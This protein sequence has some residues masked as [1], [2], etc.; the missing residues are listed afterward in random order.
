MSSADTLEQ[1]MVDRAEELKVAREVRES[2][3]TPNTYPEA[4]ES[5]YGTDV[6]ETVTGRKYNFIE[7]DLT[8]FTLE[9]IAYPLSTTN[10]FG[11]HAKPFWSVAQHSVFVVEILEAQ[12]VYQNH[13]LR[14]GLMHD[15]AEAM[16]NDVPRPLKPRIGEAYVELTEIADDA[17]GRRF[18]I[19]EYMM[20]G[21]TV[22]MADRIALVHE[23]HRVMRNGPPP[24][25]LA[26]YPLP[27]GLK[28]P[29]PMNMEEAQGAYEGVALRLGIH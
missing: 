1:R 10:R 8:D 25:D 19:V 11:N 14:A 29:E 20:H 16:L 17:I 13:I 12:G 9:D 27:D 28:L 7:P 6:I 22:K 24:E 2:G 23:G 26:A 3:N 5:W 4:G 15:A 18:H 21:K